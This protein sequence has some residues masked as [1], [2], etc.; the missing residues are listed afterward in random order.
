MK[1]TEKKEIKNVNDQNVYY[2]KQ[3]SINKKGDIK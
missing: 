2:N 3:K 1:K